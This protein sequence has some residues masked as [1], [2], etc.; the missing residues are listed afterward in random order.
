MRQRDPRCAL[1]SSCLHVLAR[2]TDDGDVVLIQSDVCAHSVRLLRRVQTAVQHQDLEDVRR[3]V[4]LP[5][6]RGRRRLENLLR[7]RRPLPLALVDGR[8]P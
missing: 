5:P 4:Q 6:D 7:P 3:R 2:L 1:L 8:H